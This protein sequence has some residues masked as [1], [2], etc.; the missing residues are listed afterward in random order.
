LS[1]LHGWG[2]AACVVFGLQFAPASHAAALGP[3]AI[4][5]WIA[6]VGFIAYGVHVHSRKLAGISIIGVGVGLILVASYRGLSV[7]TAM[8]GSQNV[9]GLSALVPVIG[10]FCSLLITRDSISSLE[11]AAIVVISLGVAI[12]SLPVHVAVQE[13]RQRWFHRRAR[14]AD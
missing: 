6:L 9:G 12:A 11:W 14:S 13:P 4:A 5:A 10:A 7:P 3:G 8:I 2:M 1:F